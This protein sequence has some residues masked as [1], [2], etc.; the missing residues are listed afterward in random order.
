MTLNSVLAGLYAA[1]CFLFGVKYGERKMK[2][3]KRRLSYLA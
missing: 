2:K 1:A 3:Y